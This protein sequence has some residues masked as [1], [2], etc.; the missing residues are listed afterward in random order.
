MS[1][2]TTRLEWE[3]AGVDATVEPEPE[4]RTVDRT[5]PIA[6]HRAT[7]TVLTTRAAALEAELEHQRRHHQ[8][9]IQRY[10]RLLA[11]AQERASRERA[12]STRERENESRLRRVLDRLF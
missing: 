3:P 10:E 12:A 5:V 1:T 6:A 8:Q 4:E 9:V 7:V 2:D 11:D